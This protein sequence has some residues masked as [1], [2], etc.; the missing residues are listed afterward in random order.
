MTGLYLAMAQATNPKI[1]ELRSRIK[2][3]P[4]SRLFFPLAEE[5]RKMGGLDEAEQA[6]RTG[7]EQHPTYLSAWVSLG[8]VLRERGDGAGVVEVLSKAL[9]LDPGNVVAA[10]ILADTYFDMGQKVEAIKKYKLV[11]ALHPQD[12]DVEALIEALDSELNPKTVPPQAIPSSL[13][14]EVSSSAQETSS[15]PQDFSAVGP[16]AMTDQAPSF[17]GAFDFRPETTETEEQPSFVDNE[18][19]SEPA[20]A[21][22]G[23]RID[24]A[25]DEAIPSAPA[26][27]EQTSDSRF[28]KEPPASPPEE[29][30]SGESALSRASQFDDTAPLGY[31][32]HAF[33]IE[34]PAGMHISGPEDGSA[35]A[36]LVG[37]SRDDASA[38]DAVPASSSPA[39]PVG[40]DRPGD[41]FATDHEVPSPWSIRPAAI[42]DRQASDR[43]G[44]DH[45]G[46]EAHEPFGASGGAPPL[47]FGTDTTALPPDHAAD[48]VT[49]TI[50]M[51]DLYARQGLV[52]DAREIY[53][54]VLERDPG[55]ES[56]RAKLDHLPQAPAVRSGDDAAA[57]AA[58]LQAWLSRVKRGSGSV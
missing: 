46:A 58:R 20:A 41:L 9:Q 5:L 22:S 32:S 52:D 34:H 10:R 50:T 6:L 48:D 40:E 36:T 16:D 21:F 44:G 23:E 24:A 49:N 45:A 30:V 56:I 4:K 51:G 37:S 35:D 31:D 54:R 2:T 17:P 38:W 29:P 19:P 43:N 55:N 39:E 53:G 13:K 26:V 33:A 18:T 25:A 1:E 15:S 57:K 7:L 8:R 14:Q 11:H 42:D 27:H 47:S 12:Q 28:G 3:D